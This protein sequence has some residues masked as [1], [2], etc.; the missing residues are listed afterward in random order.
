MLQTP[1]YWLVSKRLFI[2]EAKEAMNST[3]L[4]CGVTNGNKTQL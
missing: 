3:A 2:N 1:V 4:Q